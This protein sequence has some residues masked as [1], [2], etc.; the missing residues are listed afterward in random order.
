MCGAISSHNEPFLDL[1]LALNDNFQASE[2]SYCDTHAASRKQVAACEQW[3]YPDSATTLTLEGC[4]TR[5]TSAETLA[6]M[7]TCDSCGATVKREKRLT[8][9][10]LPNVLVVHLKRFDALKSRKVAD[11]VDFPTDR[12][13][14]L[15]PFL[16][17]WR[18]TE[19]TFSTPP[20]QLYELNAVVNHHGD[21]FKGHY[22]TFVKDGGHWFH[23]DDHLVTHVDVDTVKRSE[24]YILFYVREA[25][26]RLHHRQSD[27]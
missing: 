21:M 16:S 9:D 25:I 4:L 27:Q 2:T 24:G 3:T 8:I 6:D 11:V 22:T 26:A 7:H 5:F 1:S 17:K 20:K 13:L 14:D 10:K 15:G 19:A 23:C 18:A 12:P